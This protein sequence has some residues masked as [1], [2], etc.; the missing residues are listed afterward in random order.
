MIV[1]LQGHDLRVVLGC[2][3]SWTCLDDGKRVVVKRL[4]HT[5]VEIRQEKE[6][7]VLPGPLINAACPGYL[8]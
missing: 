6:A 1:K 2:W 7:V 4:L 8:V 5:S 3:S